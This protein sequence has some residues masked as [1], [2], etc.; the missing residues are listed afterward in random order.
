MILEIL[1]NLD[2]NQSNV[3]LVITQFNAE[4]I[5]NFLASEKSQENFLQSENELEKTT[6]KNSLDNNVSSRHIVNVIA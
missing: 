6:G 4:T 1:K 5:A 3:E 2:N